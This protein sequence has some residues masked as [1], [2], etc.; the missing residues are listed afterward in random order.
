[1]R[2]Q[3]VRERSGAKGAVAFTDEKFRRVPAVV[4]ADVRVNELRQ[5]FYVLIDAPEILVL[6]FADGVAEACAHRVNED[7]IRFVQEAVR[8][9][10]SL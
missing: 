1:M 5:G 3:I 10:E 4:A 6:G 8:I 7:Q 2:L 9:S